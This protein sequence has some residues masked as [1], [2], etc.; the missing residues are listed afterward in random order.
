MIPAEKSRGLCGEPGAGRR[1]FGGGLVVS[2][3]SRKTGTEQGDVGLELLDI[4]LCE[5]AFRGL[6]PVSARLIIGKLMPC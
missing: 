4:P 2:A 1:P 6:G 3:E 5:C